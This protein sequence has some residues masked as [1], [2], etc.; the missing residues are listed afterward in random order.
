MIFPEEFQFLIFHSSGFAYHQT[1]ERFSLRI[2]NNSNSSIIST[3]ILNCSQDK[4]FFLCDEEL[5]P[6]FATSVNVILTDKMGLETG[7]TDYFS[8]YIYERS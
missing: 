1:S 5:T 3:K 7:K 2:Q 4:I 6:E 8:L